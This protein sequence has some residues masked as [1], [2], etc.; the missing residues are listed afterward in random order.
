[1]GSIIEIKYH[2]VDAMDNHDTD[3]SLGEKALSEIMY[4]RIWDKYIFL[5]FCNIRHISDEPPPNF[6]NH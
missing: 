6:S 4:S 2:N 1:M 3:L 5:S